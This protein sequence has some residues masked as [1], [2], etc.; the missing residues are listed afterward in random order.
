MTNEELQAA[1]ATLREGPPPDAETLQAVLL[2]ASHM[3][4]YR[5]ELQAIALRIA[6]SVERTVGG[7]VALSAALEPFVEALQARIERDQQFWSVINA[8]QKRLDYVQLHDPDLY[9]A[10]EK[11]AH[12]F[13][14]KDLGL[15]T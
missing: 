12:E 13:D 14:R 6:H 9:A 5:G 10:A 1:V 3:T 8:Q 7:F 2:E 15:A 4:T 11:A